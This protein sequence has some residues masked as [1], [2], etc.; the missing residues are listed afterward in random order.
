MKTW[1]S[2]EH[3]MSRRTLADDNPVFKRHCEPRA[4]TRETHLSY[5]RIQVHGDFGLATDRVILVNSFIQ[6]PNR[7]H[8]SQRW[9]PLSRHPSHVF[10]GDL[11]IQLPRQHV[12]N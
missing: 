2:G 10:V 7:K 6:T 1:V 11:G 5:H 9:V 4:A 8:A 3:D 12:K